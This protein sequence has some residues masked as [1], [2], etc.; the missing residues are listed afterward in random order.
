MPRTRR[1]FTDEFKQEAVKLVKHPGAKVAH[2]ARHL[3]I[4]Q[5]VL[6]RWVSQEHGGRFDTQPHKPMRS[7]SASE[8]ERRQ[9]ELRRVTAEREILKNGLWRAGRTDCEPSAYLWLGSGVQ[10]AAQHP[11]HG[12]QR[13]G[14]GAGCACWWSGLA[15]RRMGGRLHARPN[16]HRRSRP[17]PG[18]HHGRL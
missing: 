3:G 14:R 5:S 12:L 13:R 6:R 2:I 10:G 11:V 4:E 7:E 16:A 8:V 9:R 1:T 18:R 17:T 15:C